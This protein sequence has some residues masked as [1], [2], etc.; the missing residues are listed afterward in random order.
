M[1]PTLRV[2]EA[3][4]LAECLARISGT[5]ELAVCASRTSRISVS[6]KETR[7]DMDLRLNGVLNDPIPKGCS[8]FTSVATTT[9]TTTDEIEYDL[10]L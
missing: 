10:P 1:T 9:T 4:V 6:H 5:S 3:E 2:A 7:L 8:D